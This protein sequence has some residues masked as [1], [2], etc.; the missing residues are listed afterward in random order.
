MAHKM[1]QWR[2][3][4]EKRVAY[5]DAG[6]VA[7]GSV[8]VGYFSKLERTARHWGCMA[9]WTGKGRPHVQHRLQMDMIMSNPAVRQ[10]REFWRGAICA[11]RRIRGGLAIA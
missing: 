11:A 6:T 3:A 9:A 8:E 2:R 1:K 10:D 4:M 5:G 7:W